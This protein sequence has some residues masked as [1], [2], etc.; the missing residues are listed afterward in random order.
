MT[1]SLKSKLP[2]FFWFLARILIGFF[3]AYAGFT[4]LTEPVENFRGVLSQYQVIPY[5]FL[6]WIAFTVPW[7]E[8]MA[9]TFMILGYAPRL[10]SLATA[11]LCLNFLIVLGASDVLLDSGSKDCGCF[12]EGSLI[13]LTVRQIFVL[14]FLNMLL[15]LKLASLK[16][17]PLSLDHLLRKK[18]S[19]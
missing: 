7:L 16:T 4:K 12:G 2:D 11:F 5:A 6:P 8:L 9:G 19:G 18:T 1:A 17:R 10:A 13:H 14:D 15:S 3:F